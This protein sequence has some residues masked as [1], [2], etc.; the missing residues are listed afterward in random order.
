MIYAGGY[1]L[2][3][4]FKE[5]KLANSYPLPLDMISTN[6][7]HSGDVLGGKVFQQVD[8]LKTETV[9][10]DFLNIPVGKPTERRFYLVPLRYDKDAENIMY[11]VLCVNNPESIEKMEKLSVMLPA[12]ESGDCLEFR[13]VVQNMTADTKTRAFYVLSRRTELVGVDGILRNPLPNYYYERIIPFIVYE[14]QTFGAEWITVAIGAA[15]LLG[16]IIPAVVLGIK[17]HRERY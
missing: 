14:R 12:P 9:Q 3:Y 2:A 4:G 6:T 11:F 8:C 16:G 10:T 13:G 7:I 15:L 17:I 5:L 1:F